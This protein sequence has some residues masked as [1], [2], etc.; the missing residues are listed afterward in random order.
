MMSVPTTLRALL[1]ILMAL[2]LAFFSV[3]CDGATEGGMSTS[4]QAL[5][6]S[7]DAESPRA[8]FDVT[9]RVSEPTSRDVARYERAQEQATVGQPISA[10]FEFFPFVA[11]AVDLGDINSTFVAT[12]QALNTDN[13]YV[14]ERQVRDALDAPLYTE[15]P[16]VS[17]RGHFPCDLV[18]QVDV[19]RLDFSAAS[20][21]DVDVEAWVEVSDYDLQIVNVSRIMGN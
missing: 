16:V 3:A 21:L 5:S 11:S 7:L 15:L 14:G 12:A 9:I 17:C 10:I 18:V 2:S 4:S 13:E 6:A 20:T 19:E 8:T 1:T